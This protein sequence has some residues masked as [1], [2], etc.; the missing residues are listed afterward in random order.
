MAEEK[1]L[2]KVEL[3]VAEALARAEKLKQTLEEL[4]KVRAAGGDTTGLEA[5]LNQEVNALGAVVVQQKQNAGT[6]EEVIRQK[7]KL[8]SVVTMLGGRFGGLVGQLASVGELLLQMGPAVGVVAGTLAGTTAIVAGWQ[9]VNRELKEAAERLEHFRRAKEEVVKGEMSP[10]RQIEGD[11]LKMGLLE[12]GRAEK[13]YDY[14]LA[15]M[16]QGVPKDLALSIAPEAHAAGLPSQSASIL[17]MAKAA[18]VEIADTPRA[19]KT[20][21]E[22]MSAES[23]LLFSQQ[24]V[25]M[26]TT[27]TGRDAIGEAANMRRMK[28]DDPGNWLAYMGG[29]TDVRTLEFAKRMGLLDPEAGRQDVSK[30]MG[31]LARARGGRRRLRN[32]LAGRSPDE[33]GPADEVPKPTP[34]FD[35]QIEE[36]ERIENI[37]KEIGANRAAED[38]SGPA[39]GYTPRNGTVN[40]YNLYNTTNQ[41]VVLNAPDPRM[42][43]PGVSSLN[44]GLADAFRNRD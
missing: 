32:Y 36:L 39:P 20:A 11:L 21:D 22:R 41:G 1:E 15:M 25:A 24:L 35:R 6:T 9:A 30:K 12:Q 37:Y 8:A 40:V 19:M 17:A 2:L 31:E 4:D 29:T 43:T 10:L 23:R 27:L 34:Q 5:R 3:D 16:S 28:E 7:E 38:A 26:R 18:G 14:A 42:R 13:V 33:D 44:P